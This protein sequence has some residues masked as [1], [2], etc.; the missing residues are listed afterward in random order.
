MVDGGRLIAFGPAL[1]IIAG[2]RAQEAFTAA[3][4]LVVVGTA[5]LFDSVGLN[6]FLALVR[7]DLKL[8]FSNKRALLITLAAPIASTASVWTTMPAPSS[9]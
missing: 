3:A 9:R 4:L 1:R 7:K 8:Y 5:L 6:A 2:T